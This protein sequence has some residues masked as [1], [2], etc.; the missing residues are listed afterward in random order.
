MKAG[1]AINSECR[2]QDSTNAG[3]VGVERDNHSEKERSSLRKQ[4]MGD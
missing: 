2:E 4:V 1:K 3:T